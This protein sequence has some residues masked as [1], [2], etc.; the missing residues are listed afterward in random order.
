VRMLTLQ[1]MW[2]AVVAL[3]RNRTVSDLYKRFVIAEGDVDAETADVNFANQRRA[4]SAA[5]REWLR[6]SV[7]HGDLDALWRTGVRTLVILAAHDQVIDLE[8]LQRLIA[9]YAQ[10]EIF[11]DP[12]Q[13]HGWNRAAVER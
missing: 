7:Q 10:I 1:P 9:P 12:D 11:V 5:T 4:D 6:D 3:S 2:G 13:G 8:R